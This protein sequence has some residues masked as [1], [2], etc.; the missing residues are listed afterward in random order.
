VLLALLWTVAERSLGLALVQHGASI[1]ALPVLQ[2]ARD[3]A[4]RE[5]APDLATY[6]DALAAGLR[7][8]GRLRDAHR[9][10]RESL[11]LGETAPALIARAR[12]EIEGG[13]L[14]AAFSD[15][16]RARELGGTIDQPLADAAAAARDVPGWVHAGPLAARAV[17]LHVPR[18]ADPALAVEVAEQLGDGHAATSV[19][20]AAVAQLGNEPTRTALR[21]YVDLART[22]NVQAARAAI[23]VYQALPEL[24]RGA[25]DEMWAITRGE[26]AAHATDEP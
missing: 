23:S 8:R 20:T 24:E 1:V 7:A 18:D 10:H 25:Y 14:R 6:D 12:T 3:R 5:H 19:L 17:P 22:G 21:I 15:L 13:E 16:A 9:Y 11:A 26:S 2:D 4:L